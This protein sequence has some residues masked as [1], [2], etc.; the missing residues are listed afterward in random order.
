VMCRELPSG[1]LDPG[2]PEPAPRTPGWRPLER[3]TAREA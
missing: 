2:H 3:T 1:N